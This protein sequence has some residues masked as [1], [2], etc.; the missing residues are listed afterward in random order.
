MTT[1]APTDEELRRDYDER[2]GE[3]DLVREQS[4]THMEAGEP[5]S[6][7]AMG[8]ETAEY[9]KPL[10]DPQWLEAWKMFVDSEGEYGV[11]VRVP[12]GQW[13][14]VPD[15]LEHMRRPDG[16][17][18]FQ[19]STPERVLKGEYACFVGDCKKM[20]HRRIQLVQHVRAFHVAEAQTFKE[21]LERIEKQVA[22]EDP[23]L[24]KLVDSLKLD[25]TGDPAPDDGFEVPPAGIDV[26][27]DCG[28]QAPDGHASPARWL[29]GHTIGA[30]KQKVSAE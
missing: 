6:A 16:G 20:L 26:C 5:P 3:R 13:S 14:G 25:E 11:L 1:Q 28:K 8:A 22:A 2:R 23:R 9:T 24:Q 17:H 29:Q 10:I 30:H 4:L 21:V 19:L 27:S 15:A 18:W 7:S 12:R